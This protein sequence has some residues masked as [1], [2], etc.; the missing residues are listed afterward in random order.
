[1][2]YTQESGQNWA[3]FNIFSKFWAFKVW[4]VDFLRK[5]CVLE[6]QR[7]QTRILNFFLFLAEN[8]HV[9]FLSAFEKIVFVIFSLLI[10]DPFFRPLK[11]K[12][13]CFLSFFNIFSI[14]AGRKRR[15]KSRSDKIANIIF[16]TS[17]ED[18]AKKKLGYYN[19]YFNILVIFSKIWVKVWPHFYYIWI[20]LYMRKP[21]AC[22]ASYNFAKT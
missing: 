6:F 22:G 19:K 18:S 4:N 14:S 13:G 1:M 2:G 16:N 5:S 3:K 11:A 17:I 10:F 15:K 12:N 21:C 20:S 7:K 8:W 9:K